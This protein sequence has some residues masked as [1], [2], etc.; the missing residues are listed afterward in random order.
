M[1]K[2]L[3]LLFAVP[4]LAMA[5]DDGIKKTKYK[6]F[7][8]NPVAVYVLGDTIPFFHGAGTLTIKV[9]TKHEPF[10]FCV[11]DESETVYDLIIWVDDKYY[12]FHAFKYRDTYLGK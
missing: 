4:V 2:L 3:L 7:F 8:E 9:K 12:D 5:Q 11:Y 10:Y 1:K 6:V